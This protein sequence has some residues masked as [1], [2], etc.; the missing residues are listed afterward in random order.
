LSGT[1]LVLLVDETS[2][3][4]DQLED[5]YLRGQSFCI[6]DEESCSRV[7]EAWEKRCDDWKQVDADLLS[8]FGFHLGQVSAYDVRIRTVVDYL[9]RS[10][11]VDGNTLDILCKSI[12]L[13]KSRLAHL[14]KQQIGVSLGSYM[15]FEK[16]RKTYG[17][18]QSGEDLTTACIHAGFYS[19]S[20]FSATYRRMFGLSCRDFHHGTI[21]HDIS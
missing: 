19:S 17:Y 7:T 15:V 10:E 2:S 21:I 8:C 4:S 11:T 13:S 18:V 12:C 3:L 20:H 16:V 14:F 9:H 6:L 5:I 1:L